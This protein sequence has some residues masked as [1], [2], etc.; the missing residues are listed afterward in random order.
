[1]T[2][3]RF[4]CYRC[5]QEDDADLSK[6]VS[7]AE[8]NEPLPQGKRLVIVLFCDDCLPHNVHLN[9]KKELEDIL[10]NAPRKP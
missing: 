7:Y 9:S 6:I 10:Q 1:M 8:H 5:Q 2:V 3:V 4:R